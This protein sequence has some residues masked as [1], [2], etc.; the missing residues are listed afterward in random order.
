VNRIDLLP[1]M[2]RQPPLEHIGAPVRQSAA[3]TCG[4]DWALDQPAA[5][6]LRSSPRSAL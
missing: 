4:T 5:G 6:R 3:A 2:P 1:G